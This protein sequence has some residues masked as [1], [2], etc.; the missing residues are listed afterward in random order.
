MKSR[1][2][3]FP[4]NLRKLPNEQIYEM[5][6]NTIEEAENKLKGMK[7]FEV[8]GNVLIEDT[9]D[10]KIEKCFIND[11]ET[12]PFL[13]ELIEE[14]GI[15][16]IDGHMA[17]GFISDALFYY[18]GMVSDQMLRN[19]N[20]NEVTIIE[21]IEPQRFVV[22]EITK[23]IERIEINEMKTQNEIEK[24][25]YKTVEYEYGKEREFP[26][27]LT[28]SENIIPIGMLEKEKE[29]VFIDR[30]NG[31]EHVI[32]KV[33]V[34]ETEE[35]SLSLHNYLG[36][37]IPITE[38][39]QNQPK[40]DSIISKSSVIQRIEQPIQSSY[41]PKYVDYL[42][43][44]YKQEN[45]N[46]EEILSIMITIAREKKE[47]VKSGLYTY[48]EISVIVKQMRA[49]AHNNPKVLRNRW[50]QFKQEANQKKASTE[51]K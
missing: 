38:A 1:K 31:K 14:K 49:E 21:I 11:V 39:T 40:E 16:C 41:S 42:E 4:H 44:S 47:F 7:R 5:I 8:S 2:N 15:Q 30:K 35:Y 45:K 23:T 19:Q 43:E 22:K 13:K 9:S 50:E 3:V 17:T 25:E 26:E 29:Y 48:D 33:T 34:N 28:S 46:N 37:I 12:S 32:G 6:K 18:S 36:D 51:S 24:E 27:Q 20:N 10:V